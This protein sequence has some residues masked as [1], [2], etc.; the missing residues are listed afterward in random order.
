MPVVNTDL[1]NYAH[2]HNWFSIDL[3]ITCL[4]FLLESEHFKME[5]MTYSSVYAQL[6]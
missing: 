1:Y 3:V 6:L 4:F 5:A 2:S